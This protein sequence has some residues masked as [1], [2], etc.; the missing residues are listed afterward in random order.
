[1]KMPKQFLSFFSVLM[2]GAFM[3]GTM[4]LN[5]A[6]DWFYTNVIEY[7]EVTKLAVIPTRKDVVV[8]DSRPAK[9]RYN[10][11]HIPGAISIPDTMFDKM[12]DLLPEDKSTQLV[13][14]CGGLKC[15]LSHKSA[16]KAEA[17]GYTNIAVYAKGMP[18]WIANGGLVSVAPD[19]V[20]KAIEKKT[21]YVFDTRPIKRKYAKGHVPG[22]I[23]MPNSQFDK[24]L[25]VLPTDK[26]AEVIFYCGGYH[27]PL[28]VKSAN[29]AMELGYTN[30]KVFQ[31]GYP[32]WKAAYGPGANGME[33][34][35]KAVAATIEA[36]ED[37]DTI[38]VASFQ[39]IMQDKPDSIYLYDVR[40]PEEFANGSIAGALN[41]PVENLE[42]E[43]DSMP[44]DK[45]IVFI[46]ATG[47]RSGEAYDI[48]KML[49]EERKVFFLDATLEFEGDGK[50]AIA[51]N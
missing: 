20:K 43:F 33:P 2:V 17:L 45:P 14:Y 41:M 34:F 12:T 10:N 7:D 4:T 47:A 25:D 15:K 1:M 50:Y 49:D 26:E 5:A 51:Q 13:F 30:V 9:R 21:A 18:D 22:A 44:S 46:C 42:D 11:E 48:V 19:Y 23:A 40:D 38:T 8:I 32:A 3:F 31:A 24:H 6:E 28:S 37:G 29:K 36:G 35:E 16:F 39:A 27:C